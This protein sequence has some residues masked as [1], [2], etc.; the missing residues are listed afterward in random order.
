MPSTEAGWLAVSKGFEDKWN[1]P[2]CL[3]ALDGKHV[4]VRQPPNSGSEFFNYKHFFSVVLMALVDSNYRFIYVDVGATGRSGDA[5][6]F[7]RGTLKAGMLT[8]LLGFPKATLL[9][10]TGESCQYHI[11]GDDAFPLREDLMKPYPSRG[12]TKEQRI[13]NY[14]LSRARRVV[15]NAFGILSNR[16]RVFLSPICL[17]PDKVEKIILATV[18]LHNYLIDTKNIP[19]KI[20]D[21]EDED[22]VLIPGDWRADTGTCFHDPPPATRRNH[23]R[24]A[25]QQRDLLKDYFLSPTG[26]V[27]W[28]NAII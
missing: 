11:V 20:I 23:S 25:K 28:Q 10:D 1:Y 14:R 22:H 24:G 8:G 27:A 19:A 26:Q 6:V 5:G 12:L 9:G 3:G 17:D 7:D 2:L 13:F 18:C 4:A 15:E 21:Q 16:F